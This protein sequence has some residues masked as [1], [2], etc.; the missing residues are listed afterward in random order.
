[1]NNIFINFLLGIFLCFLG[2]AT[3]NSEDKTTAKT[4]VQEKMKRFE[5]LQDNVSSGTLQAGLLVK[6]MRTLYGE[7]DDIFS[8]GSST[9]Q[10]EIWTYEEVSVKNKPTGHPIRL[11]INNGKLVSWTY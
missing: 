4:E 7:P 10:F 1:M 2:C 9:G 5:K 8:S 3:V 11:Y 6:D